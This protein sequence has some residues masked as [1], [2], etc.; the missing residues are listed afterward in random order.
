MHI[1]IVRDDFSYFLHTHG[2]VPDAS[3]RGIIPF[4]DAHEDSPAP[5]DATRHDAHEVPDAFGP[6]VDGHVTFPTPGTYAV[7]GEFEHERNIIVT[8]F[9]I[10]VR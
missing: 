7:F 1:A 8:R 6:T 4:A 9:L 2:E 5:A 10:D 3:A